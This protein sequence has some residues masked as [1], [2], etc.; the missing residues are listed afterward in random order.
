MKKIA[1]IAIV[2]GLSAG[3]LLG[4]VLRES[5]P[6]EASAADAARLQLDARRTSRDTVGLIRQ[7]QATLESNGEDPSR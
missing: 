4:G 7:L 5:R 1:L 6:S 2:L 3:A